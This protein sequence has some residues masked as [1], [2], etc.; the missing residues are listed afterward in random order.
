MEVKKIELGPEICIVQFLSIVYYWFA[1]ECSNGGFGEVP[2]GNS[3]S[4]S[5]NVKLG[6]SGVGRGVA[7]VEG[8]LM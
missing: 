3:D 1:G 5:E 2:T 4:R 6:C 8:F 7:T